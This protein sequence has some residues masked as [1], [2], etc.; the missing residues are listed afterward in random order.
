MFKLQI[1]KNKKIYSAVYYWLAIPLPIPERNPDAKIV[2]WFLKKLR[3]GIERGKPVRPS[4]IIVH[5]I[6]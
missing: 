1:N 2:D 3:K 6:I 4:K 5:Q